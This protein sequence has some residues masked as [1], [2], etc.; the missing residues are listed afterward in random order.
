MGVS[1]SDE[2]AERVMA[3]VQPR[4]LVKLAVAGTVHFKAD[5]TISSLACKH[6]TIVCLLLILSTLPFTAL[7]ENNKTISSLACKHTTIVCLLLILPTL[8]FTALKENNEIEITLT[9]GNIILY[10]EQG[11]QYI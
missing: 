8:P 10:L 3:I 6:T 11:T 2:C 9:M 5:K 4:Y 1:R 7:K